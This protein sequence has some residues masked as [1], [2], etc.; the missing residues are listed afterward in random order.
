MC[1]SVKASRCAAFRALLLPFVACVVAEEMHSEKISDVGNSLM[2]K[3]GMALS[4]VELPELMLDLDELDDN[5]LLSREVAE[6]AEDGTCSGQ[7]AGQESETLVGLNNRSEPEVWN[8]SEDFKCLAI[9]VLKFLVLLALVAAFDHLRFWLWPDKVDQASHE[10]G[11]RNK[12]T[13]NVDASDTWGCTDLHSAAESNSVSKLQNCLDGGA[14]ILA[15]DCWDETALHFAAKAGSAECCDILLARGA[16][17]NAENADGRTPLMVAAIAGKEDV[18]SLLLQ[19]GAHAG[20]VDDTEIPG[21][22]STLILAD[23][24]SK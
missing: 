12:S 21:M 15:R 1:G 11:T 24:L 3:D 6:P 5:E 16:E 20:D 4:T 19:R 9:L 13:R 17:V 8:L 7:C 22:L 14:D 23:I 10:R 2:Q 18:C